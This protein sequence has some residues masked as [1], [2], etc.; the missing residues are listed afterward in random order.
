M[1]PNDSFR[2][3]MDLLGGPEFSGS[4]LADL[5]AEALI[6]ESGI[7][8][9]AIRDSRGQRAVM[10]MCITNQS[11]DIHFPDLRDREGFHI[12]NDWGK[13][14]LLEAI[15]LSLR[16]PEGIAFF[17][18]TDSNNRVNACAFTCADPDSISKLSQDFNLDS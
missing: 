2:E 16:A 10:V 17:R 14:S 8:Y 6:Q 18:A 4:T 9:R 13:T 3:T 1:T 15:V 5:Q 7:A 12:D 11:L